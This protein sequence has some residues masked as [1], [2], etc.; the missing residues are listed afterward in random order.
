MKKI[1]LI[2]VLSFLLVNCTN[3]SESDLMETDT[4][5]TIKLTYTKDI[6]PIID[7]NCLQCHNNP[8][9]NSAPSS[10]NTY[11]L[12]K[13]GAN[14]IQSRMNNTSAPMPQSGL[15]PAATRAKFDQWITDG[16]LE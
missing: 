3:D 6:K 16:K 8:P 11:E 7:N 10:Y 5:P 15:L 1:F 14:S 2:T 4:D 12:V 13:N 9:T